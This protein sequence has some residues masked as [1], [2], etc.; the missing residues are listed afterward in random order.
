MNPKR[1]KDLLYLRDLM[2]AGEE[3]ITRIE[4]DVREIARSDASAVHEIRTA[5]NNMGLVL[6]GALQSAL[7]EVA[8][9]VA[10]RF[11]IGPE[12]ALSDVRGHLTDFWIIL[13]DVL[14]Y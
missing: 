13:R 3:V 4:D 5:H 8:E 7:P 11:G 12:A 2:A 10:V 6:T 14:N 1:A 9:A